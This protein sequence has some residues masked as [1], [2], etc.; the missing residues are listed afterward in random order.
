MDI[1]RTYGVINHFVGVCCCLFWN[2]LL[3][4]TIGSCSLYL[5]LDLTALLGQSEHVGSLVNSLPACQ[6]TVVAE[7]QKVALWSEGVCE[8]FT[9]FW[10]QDDSAKVCIDSMGVSVEK[11]D[12]LADHV[13]AS[14]E[15]RPGLAVDRVRMARGIDVGI[16]S[17]EGAVNLESG[18]ICWSRPVSTNWIA[19][20]IEKEQIGNLD[21][22]EM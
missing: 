7:D 13:Q 2:K 19:A 16:L 20:V 5:Q 15:C 11:A 18:C 10:V 22:A 17:V 21:L 14:S 1:G 6:Q 8:T 9:L 12:V 3:L 4:N